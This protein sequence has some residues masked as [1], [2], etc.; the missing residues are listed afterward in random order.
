MDGLLGASPEF[1]LIFRE[2]GNTDRVKRS[3]LPF[4]LP[5]RMF[6]NVIRRKPVNNYQTEFIW[7]SSNSENP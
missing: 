5:L 7:I 6:C 3:A 1:A 2:T 4:N